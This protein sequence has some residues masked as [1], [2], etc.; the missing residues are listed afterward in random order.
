[1]FLPFVTNIEE[2]F[3]AESLNVF[4]LKRP[5]GVSVEPEGVLTLLQWALLS[6]VAL[7]LRRQGL[8]QPWLGGNL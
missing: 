4:F 7:V 5:C 1:M 8:L 2:K 3:T 6:L